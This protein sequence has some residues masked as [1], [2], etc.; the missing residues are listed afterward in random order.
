M[1]AKP[2]NQVAGRLKF[3]VMNGAELEL[4]GNFE[5]L[6]A[7][8]PWLDDLEG[9]FRIHG[10][11]ATKLLTLVDCLRTSWSIQIP[12]IEQERYHV[13]L[14]L[15][16]A[17][18]NEGQPLEFSAVRLQLHHL[19]HW[20]GKTGTTI[21]STPDEESSRMRQVQITHTPLKKM[22]VCTDVGEIEL[23]FGYTLKPS[24]TSAFKA[25]PIVEAT[26]TQHN[27]LGFRFTALQPLE[28]AL[29]ICTALQNM[30]TIGVNAPVLVKD[31]SLEH[32]DWLANSPNRTVIPRKLT[33]YTQFQGTHSPREDKSIHTREMLFTFDDI[34]GLEGVAKWLKVAE[35]YSVAIGPLMN[36]WYIPQT[37]LENRFLQCLH[38]A[39]TLVRIRSQKQNI[40]KFN[41]HLLSLTDEAGSA[42]TAL[43]GDVH[44]WISK[45]ILST[46]FSIEDEQ[47][48][49]VGERVKKLKTLLRPHKETGNQWKPK[50]AEGISQT[51]TRAE[52]ESEMGAVT[53]FL[54]KIYHEV[55]SN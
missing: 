47:S 7:P 4:I 39:E 50:L 31:V 14:V 44:R 15:T 11:A 33:L 53:D 10:A 17:Y 6:K 21:D 5:G 35:K 43:V 30:V 36:Q 52:A 37:T 48:I 16:N 55:G 28:N 18:F 19:E 34:G 27:T 29:K 26:I 54:R 13:P 24:P 41:K 12:G 42:F 45:V 49:P 38:G 22:A 32:P 3:D 25:E 9:P 51:I 20:V 1:D 8:Q 2:E 40:G 23:T 46:V